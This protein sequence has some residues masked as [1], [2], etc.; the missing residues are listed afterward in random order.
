LRSYISSTDAVC[1]RPQHGSYAV[2]FGNRMLNV[3]A[4]SHATD[5]KSF[6]EV[7][8]TELDFA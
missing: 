5:V 7:V 1:E 8:G 2:E 3:P 4:K 6:V